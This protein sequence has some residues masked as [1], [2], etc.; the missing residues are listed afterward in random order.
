MKFSDDQLT[1]VFEKQDGKCHLCGD[2][3]C[4]HMY[5]RRTAQGWQVDHSKAQARGGTHH[6]NNLQPAHHD[7]NNYKG[8]RSTRSVRREFMGRTTLPNPDFF[9]AESSY[10]IK[11]R[12]VTD[13]V[14][15]VA[16]AAVVV[17][18]VGVGAAL[19]SALDPQNPSR[20]AVVGGLFAAFLAAVVSGS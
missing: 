18:V 15:E 19:G 2:K 9:G 3:I 17:G 8:I 11:Q 12:R 5:G 6:L 20:G 14:A 1:Q 4:F 7:C 13:P 16:E 10:P